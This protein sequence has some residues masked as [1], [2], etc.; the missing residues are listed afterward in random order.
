MAGDRRAAERLCALAEDLAASER[1]GL[2]YAPPWHYYRSPAS[3][4][5][6]RG[7]VYR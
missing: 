4:E 7:L 5:M 1:A 6:E 3:F 2:E